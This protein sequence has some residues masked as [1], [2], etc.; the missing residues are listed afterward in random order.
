MAEELQHLMERIHAEAVQKAEAEAVKILA[1]AKDKA[2]LEIKTAEE[3]ACSILAKAETDSQVFVERGQKTL[4]QAAR[5]LLITVGQGVEKILDEIVSDA[6]TRAL[7]TDTLKKMMLTLAQAY[8]SEEGPRNRIAL[9]ISEQDQK[10]I[11]AYF[12]EMYRQKLIGGVDIRADNNVFKGFKVR[13]VDQHVEH[14]FTNEAI[15]EA[16]SNFLRPHMA[17]IVQRAARATGDKSR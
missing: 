14:Q 17:E 4:E 16:L 8:T 11:I 15:A 6:T 2:A 5:D 12:A 1:Q 9:L 7:D 3:K 13:M 10:D